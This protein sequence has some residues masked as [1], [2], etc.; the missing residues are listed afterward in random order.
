MSINAAGIVAGTVLVLQANHTD[1]SVVVKNTNFKLA[2]NADFTLANT[3]D[4]IS[5]IYNGSHWCELSRSSNA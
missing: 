1:R 2:G 4:T 3:E 5:L